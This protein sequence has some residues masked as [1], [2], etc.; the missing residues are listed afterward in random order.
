MRTTRKHKHT[1]RGGAAWFVLPEPR[2]TEWAAELG[3]DFGL[4]TG[5]GT[6]DATQHVSQYLDVIRRQDDLFAAA[7]RIIG[8]KLGVDIGDASAILANAARIDASGKELFE[9]IIDVE[10]M[11]QFVEDGNW[12]IVRQ[13]QPLPKDATKLQMMYG[14]PLSTLLLF[15]SRLNNLFILALANVIVDLSDPANPLIAANKAAHPILADQFM[16]FAHSMAYTLTARDLRDGYFLNQAISEFQMEIKD[17]WGNF[18]EGLEHVLKHTDAAAVIADKGGACKTEMA[19]EDSWGLVAAKI[20]RLHQLGRLADVLTLFADCP[21]VTPHND[22]SYTP[23]SD[24]LNTVFD[25]KGTTLSKLYRNMDDT[26]LQF[27][28]QLTHTIQKLGEDKAAQLTGK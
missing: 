4:I 3:A 27:I 18:L 16:A 24:V 15:P 8:R 10:R 6:G 22:E 14:E 12:S 2:K 19:G 1:Q 23:P 7:G 5:D 9:Y 21:N 26:T 28:L 25:G 11:I 17:F 20:L 13:G